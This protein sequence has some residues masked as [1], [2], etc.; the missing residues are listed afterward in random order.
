VHPWLGEL[1]DSPVGEILGDLSGVE[2]GSC[3]YAW[4][5]AG[6]PLSV[7][8][9]HDTDLSPAGLWARRSRI[10]LRGLPMLL[11]EAFLPA[12]GRIPSGA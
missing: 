1:G 5:A 8:A 2:R 6:H 10:L 7:R 12:M 9:L 4:L 11:Q 3:E